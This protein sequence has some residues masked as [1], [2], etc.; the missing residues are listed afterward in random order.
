MISLISSVSIPIDARRLDTK[1]WRLTSLPPPCLAVYFT[2]TFRSFTPQPGGLEFK[3]GQ[4]YYFVSTSSGSPR[5][6]NQKFGGRCAT[7]N[8]KVVFKVS[9][10]EGFKPQPTL[11]AGSNATMRSDGANSDKSNKCELI[12]D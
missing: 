4:D 5:G 6:V 3:P 9:G 2:I 12:T 10:G 8:M 11:V 1:F 7:H